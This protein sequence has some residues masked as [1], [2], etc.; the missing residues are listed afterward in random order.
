MSG[1]SLSQFEA[2]LF[3]S[4]LPSFCEA[5]HRSY[6]SDGFRRE[7]ISKLSEHD[8]YWFIKAIDLNLVTE[9][10]G[11]FVAPL[12]K[13]KEQ[14]FWQG[15]KSIEPRPITLW[16]E[17]IITIGALAK[18]YEIHDWPS[19]KLGTQSKTWAFDL[20]GYG[21]DSDDEIL[22]CEVKKSIKETDVLIELMK[23]YA[24]DASIGEPHGG[25]ERNAYKKVTGIRR[26]WPSIFWALGPTDYS[27]VYE[28]DRKNSDEFSLV[29]TNESKLGM[30]S[31]NKKRQSDA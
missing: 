10:D 3:E 16:I 17:P 14:I 20:V 12:S 23:G 21:K 9:A 29:E 18:L 24:A 11:F 22:A 6:P 4:W 25:K 13:A 31:L 7:S 26:T 28:V 30:K 8:A 5:P 27:R 15:L 2:R 1:N 19:E